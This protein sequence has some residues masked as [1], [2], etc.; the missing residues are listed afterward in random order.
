[1][2]RPAGATGRELLIGFSFKM[3]FGYQQ[4]LDWCVRARE[5]A[6]A[7]PALA[8]GRVRLFAIPSYPCL[9]PV[10]EIFRGTPIEVGAQNLHFEDGGPF[11]GEVG[12]PM[13]AEMGCTMVEVG[14]AERR[15]LFGETDE[16]V[17][18]KVA[19]AIRNGLRPLICVGE[20][21]KVSAAVAC[22]ESNRQLA[23]ALATA[24]PS[25]PVVVAYE[26]LWAIG[27]DH[28]A[29]EVH[30]AEVC[31]GLRSRLA[32]A[33]PHAADRVIYGGSAGPGLLARLGAAADGLF[34]GRYVHDVNVLEVVLDEA[35]RISGSAN[36]R[37]TGRL[38]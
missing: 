23:A 15:L 26:P 36:R 11:T 35:G 12:G 28:P 3:Y 33:R 2:T 6:L 29:T 24:A 25:A 27:A 14:H 34:L 9:P 21:E 19:S 38:L 22:R 4:T 10:L 13:L 37:Q 16:I 20:Q 30:I 31:Q 17:S 32:S 1:V 5:I 18:L 8:A 7:N